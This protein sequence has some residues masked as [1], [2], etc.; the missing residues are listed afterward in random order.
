MKKINEME[1]L[2]K[3]NGGND[4][5]GLIGGP[6]F[7]IGDWVISKKYQEM[8]VGT[9]VGRIYLLGWN[10][11][12]DVEGKTFMDSEDDLEYAIKKQTA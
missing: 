7:E 8:G 2:K 12:I 6:Q 10:Y 1:E 11:C 4:F 3:V 5:A 9:V